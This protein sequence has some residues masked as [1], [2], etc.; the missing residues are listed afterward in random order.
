MDISI[1]RTSSMP[2]YIQLKPDS[3]GRER[4]G[5]K[6]QSSNRLPKASQVTASGTEQGNRLAVSRKRQVYGEH[7]EA[8][9]S[10]TH[11]LFDLGRR[12]QRNMPPAQ[13]K[14]L[15]HCP[16]EMTVDAV[17]RTPFDVSWE[18]VDPQGNPQTPRPDRAISQF[19]CSSRIIDPASHLGLRNGQTK[20]C[21]AGKALALDLFVS[22]PEPGIFSTVEMAGSLPRPRLCLQL[23]S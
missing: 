6:K 5:S 2:V 16:S 13:S 20:F 22:R 14:R 11:S 18:K 21:P 9:Q 1:D 4:G 10:A 23:I 3:P 19:F 15:L 17:G 12:R 7:G 8:I